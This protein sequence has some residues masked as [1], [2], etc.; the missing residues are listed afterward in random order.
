LG[1]NGGRAGDGTT[2]TRLFPVAVNTGA[3][4]ALNGVTVIQ[5]AA[6]MNTHSL[7][8]GSD[9]RAYSWGTNANGQLGDGATTT[10]LVPV[11][12][13]TNVSS[14]LNGVTVIQVA[15]SINS[16]SLAVGSDGRAYSWGYNSVGQLGDGTNANR[17]F[18]VAVNTSSSSALNGVTVIQ[19]AVGYAHS[20]AVGSN[21]RAYSW[22]NNAAGQLGDGTLISRLLPIAVDTSS[23]SALNGVTVIQVAAGYIHS[24]AVGSNGRAYSWGGN[25]IGGLGDGTTTNRLF[26]V[27]VDTSSSSALTGKSVIQVAAGQYFSIA[28]A[29]PLL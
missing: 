2:I 14:A 25:I 6:S 23:S 18:P 22:G 7:A 27:A 9:G 21:G 20:L 17:L 26:P 16:H 28:V 1:L 10:R 29:F 5:V 12:V 8:V 11:A 19:V 3:S 24:L 15:A 4:S 13:N